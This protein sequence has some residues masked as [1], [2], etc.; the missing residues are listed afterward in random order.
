MEY[1]NDGV[2]IYMNQLIDWDTYFQ[3]RKGDSTDV[4]AECA[5]MLDILRT[6]GTVTVVIP[7]EAAACAGP[8]GPHQSRCNC[9]SNE[10]RSPFPEDR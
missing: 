1:L 4:D 2:L 3:R 8:V 9:E 7:Q 5:A 10:E 6:S